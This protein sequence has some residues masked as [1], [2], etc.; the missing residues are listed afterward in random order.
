MATWE[1][2]H[3]SL[4]RRGEHEVY[5]QRRRQPCRCVDVADPR[6]QVMV[7]YTPGSGVVKIAL[8]IPLAICCLWLLNFI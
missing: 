4:W 5:K 6:T 8:R 3:V 2:D 7:N 1:S